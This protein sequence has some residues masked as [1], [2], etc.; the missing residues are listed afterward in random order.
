MS[1]NAAPHNR[2]DCPDTPDPGARG[3]PMINDCA[4]QLERVKGE[5]EFLGSCFANRVHP[6]M[7]A[8][9]SG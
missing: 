9:N 3:R 5:G 1:G 6:C 2:F 8:H 7:T 4:M